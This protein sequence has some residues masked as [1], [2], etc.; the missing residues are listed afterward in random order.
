MFGVIRVPSLKGIGI[1]SDEDIA[2][3]GKM[4]FNYQMYGMLIGGIFWGILGD[5]KVDFP[6]YLVP[7]FYIQLPMF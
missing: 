6:Y 3:Y 5:K 4:L 2:M 7:Y 1:T